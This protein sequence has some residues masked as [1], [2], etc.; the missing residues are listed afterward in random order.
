MTGS[1]TTSNKI[2]TKNIFPAVIMKY[3][4]NCQDG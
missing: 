2:Y 4:E 3:Y 1:L